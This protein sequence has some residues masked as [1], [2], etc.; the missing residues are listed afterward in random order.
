MKLRLLRERKSKVRF[1]YLLR[2]CLWRHYVYIL[3]ICNMVFFFWLGADSNRL[4]SDLEELNC[5]LD[6]IASEVGSPIDKSVFT[7]CFKLFFIVSKLVL[8]HACILTKVVDNGF[9]V[10]SGRV[11]RM[12]K[13]IDKLF[14]LHVEKIKFVLHTQ[15]INQIW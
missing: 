5:A 15:K 10:L 1:F 9:C 4:E 7:I 3:C 13:R 2:S 11:H 14:V 8:T 6:L 12:Q